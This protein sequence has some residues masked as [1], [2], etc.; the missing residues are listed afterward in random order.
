MSCGI[1][2]HD[3]NIISLPQPALSLSMANQKR[4][5]LSHHVSLSLSSP[6]QPTSVSLTSASVSCLSLFIYISITSLCPS[7]SSSLIPPVMRH[8]GERTWNYSMQFRLRCCRWEW[9]VHFV[10][11]VP[12]NTSVSLIPVKAKHH[13]DPQPGPSA[14]G[15]TLVC[16]ML[17]TID[18][19]LAFIDWRFE[20]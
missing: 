5:S 6:F 3:I 1:I 15:R 9:L 4:K 2:Y 12:V 7:V 10:L 18:V 11:C 20:V 19:M 17:N 16:M 13:T 14:C 8:V